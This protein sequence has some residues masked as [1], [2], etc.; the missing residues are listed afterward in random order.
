MTEAQAPADTPSLW[1]SPPV[2]GLRGV[3]RATAGNQ[4]DTHILGT[5]GVDS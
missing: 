2:C 3:D 5:A 1:A 4:M